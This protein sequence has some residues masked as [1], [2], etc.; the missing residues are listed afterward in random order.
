[1]SA[2]L[3]QAQRLWGKRIGKLL[4][5]LIPISLLW[6]T[7]RQV[8]ITQ[9]WTALRQLNPAQMAIWLLLNLGLVILMTGRWWL[10]LRTLGHYPP[11]MALTRYRLASFAISY[12]TPGPQFGGEPIQVL[13]LRDHHGVPGTTGTASVGLDKLL[14]LIANFSFLVFGVVIALTGVWM[15]AEWRT[16]GLFFA[17]GLLIFP[18]GYLLLMLSGRQPLNSLINHLP[19]II[20]NNWISLTL[21]EVEIEMSA[22]CTAYPRTV[23]LATM[24]SVSIWVGMTC[25]YWLLTFFLGLHLSFVQAISALT[26]ARLAFLTPLPGGLGAL[27]ASQVL[28]LRYMGL[29]S[30]YGVTISLLIRLRDIIFGLTGFLGVMPFLNLRRPRN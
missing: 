23:L 6:W 29:D 17:L 9:V 21:R 5:V 2:R 14:E 19:R 27:E 7:F 3:T 28:A 11:Y 12:F 26:G 4:V 15:P 10:I 22:F 20:A 18:L 30:S 8:S 24:L 16:S 13:A 25:E 1:M